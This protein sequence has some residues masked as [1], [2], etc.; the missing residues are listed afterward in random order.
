VLNPAFNTINRE[1]T[2][3]EQAAV[4]YLREQNIE[5][6]I[7]TADAYVA[8]TMHPEVVIS[9]APQTQIAVTKKDAEIKKDANAH[10]TGRPDQRQKTVRAVKRS[11]FAWPLEQ[12]QFWLSSFFGPRKKPNGS[13]GFHYGVDMAAVRG[14]P[15]KAAAGGTIIEARYVSGYGNTVVIAHSALYKT[16][17][18]HLDTIAVQEKQ[19]VKQSDVVGTVGDTGFTIK[20]GTDASHLHFEVYERGK[21]VNPLPLLQM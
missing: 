19:T 14:T 15:V 16:R 17:Y 1:P 13:W 18:A 7:A 2:Y 12:H 6:M 20:T 3:L 11:M 10:V 9:A 4:E 8:H 5:T 21:Q